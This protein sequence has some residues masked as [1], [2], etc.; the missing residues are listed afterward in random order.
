M[1]LLVVG[2]G[3]LLADRCWLLVVVV[4]LV[5]VVCG[6]VFVVRCILRVAYSLFVMFVL[7]LIVVRCL[8]F[9]DVFSSLCV[10]C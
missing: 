10:V 6:S 3:S 5:F 8:L 9:V 4:V 2:R 7:V 1:V